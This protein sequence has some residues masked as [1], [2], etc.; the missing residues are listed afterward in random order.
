[1]HMRYL[2]GLVT[3]VALTGCARI[4]PPRRA[5][6]AAGTVT[7]T[8]Y[9][10]CGKCCGWKRTWYFAP[11]DKRT[12]KRKRVGQT[13]SG[14]QARGGTIA[15]PKEYPF[16]TIIYVEGFGYGRVEDRG[17]ASR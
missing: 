3:V 9:C 10:N 4:R 12:G 17:G 1:M 16:G 7:A 8:G 13:A 14:V 6:D 15:A 11:V 2:L 5:P